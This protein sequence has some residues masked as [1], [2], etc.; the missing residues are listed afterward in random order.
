MNV[1]L[2]AILRW[3]TPG[4][5]VKRWILLSSV[6]MGLIVFGLLIAFGQDIVRSLYRALPLARSGYCESVGFSV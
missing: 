1:S 5:R 2:R 6:S 3:L 4:M